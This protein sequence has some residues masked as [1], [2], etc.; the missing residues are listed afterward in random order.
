MPEEIEDKLLYEVKKPLFD[1]AILMSLVFSLIFT[2]IFILCVLVNVISY[3]PIQG[4]TP[5]GHNCTI[6]LLIASIVGDSVIIY[7]F[8]RLAYPWYLIRIY[9]HGTLF[10]NRKQG[11][12]RDPPKSAKEVFKLS[13]FT[14]GRFKKHYVPFDDLMELW[15]MPI[16]WGKHGKGGFIGIKEFSGQWYILQV[17]ANIDIDEVIKWFGGGFKDRWEKVFSGF[18]ND[19]FIISTL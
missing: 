7:I 17:P 4:P 13:P 11:S 16:K 12:A 3:E 8:S 6:T 14:F 9:K 1:R 5:P 10:T 15:A 2:N 18:S 19:D